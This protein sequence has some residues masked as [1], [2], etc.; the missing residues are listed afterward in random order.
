MKISS[1]WEAVAFAVAFIFSIITWFKFLGLTFT[2]GLVIDTALL[3]IFGVAILVIVSILNGF[4]AAAFKTSLGMEEELSLWEVIGST[5]GVLF[6]IILWFTFLKT[7]V[8]TI[9]STIDALGVVVPGILDISV[10]WAIGVIIINI[11][12]LVI[13]YLSENFKTELE[14]TVSKIATSVKKKT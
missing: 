11:G 6:T 4:I 7:P 9:T 14:K 8:F 12:A 2:T 10:L 1:I 13:G 5:V 3:W